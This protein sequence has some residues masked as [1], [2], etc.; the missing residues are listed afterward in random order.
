MSESERSLQSLRLRLGYPRTAA[1]IALMAASRPDS[2]AMALYLPRCD[3]GMR[4]MAPRYL[5]WRIRLAAPAP[6]LLLPAPARFRAS[7]LPRRVLPLPLLGLAVAVFPSPPFAP[8]SVA[9]AALNSCA[10]SVPITSRSVMT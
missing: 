9:L 4:R 8:P 2:L 3:L 6:A 7:L 10:I 5:P 1:L